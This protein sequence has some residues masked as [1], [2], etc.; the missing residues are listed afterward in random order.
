M[1]CIRSSRRPARPRAA[2][3]VVRGAAWLLATIAVLIL[4]STAT[5]AAGD[6]IVDRPEK[7]TYPPLSF[8]PPDAAHYRVALD[9]GMA[10]YL[11]PDRSIP[12]VT[13]TVIM[14]VG[15][16]LDPVG[17]EGLAG[18]TMYLLTR[19]G[20]ATMS[21]EQ[22]EER[23]AYLGAQLESGLGAGRGMFGFGGVPISGTE[24]RATLNLLSKDLDEGLKLL[25]DCL[26]SAAFQEDRLTL[27][28]DQQL[29]GIKRRNDES[30]G[31]EEYEWSYLANGESHWSNRYPTEA[32][33]KAI[34]RD[35]MAAFQRRYLGPKN[36]VFAVSGDFDAKVMTKKLNA[37]FAGWPT[38]GENPGPP[39]A[40]ATPVQSGWYIA[41]KEVNQTRVSIGLRTMD[42]YD[43]DYQTAQV[44]SFILG[45]GGFT[46]RLVSR[47]RSDEGLAY[48]VGC[49]F[50]D[51]LYYP[52]AWRITF[53][54]KARS[55]AFATSLALTEI[56]RMRDELVTDTEL[57]TAKN[58]F[59]E[60]FPA[61]FP[62]AASI[63]G[64][65]AAAEVTGRL[66]KDPK[67]LAEYT[68]R[69]QAVTAQ[70]VQRVAQRLLDPAKMAFLLV[71]DG[72]EMLQPDGKHDVTLTQ[73][74][75]GEP[76]RIPLRDPLTMEP[77][78]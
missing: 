2:A 66:Q 32:S 52:D 13:V 36:F 64:T 9:G 26:K 58:S 23:V 48:S 18:T 41:H 46:S 10:A 1:N 14:R 25:T 45:G 74:A 38:P 35:D 17:K 72:K 78:P 59:I 39:A 51:A 75:G 62:N 8:T 49:R 43:P 65:L 24:S 77:L 28:R 21:A 42:R 31:I 33:V 20:T 6:A 55:T 7:L 15:P 70:D 76:G 34:T 69:V 22:L 12:M 57:S 54:T 53:Q 16:D 73:L 47:I 30:S 37:A 63:A 60:G 50:D 19:S 11:V 5:L 3:D 4:G 27:R 40:P 44:M 61:R 56:N 67:Y 29:Q 71:G 68:R